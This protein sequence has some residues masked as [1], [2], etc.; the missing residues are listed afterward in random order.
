MLPSREPCER[1]SFETHILCCPILSR[2]QRMTCTNGWWLL[3]SHTPPGTFN[4]KIFIVVFA[5]L[6]PFHQLRTMTSFMKTHPTEHKHIPC[7]HRWATMSFKLGNLIA[8]CPCNREADTHSFVLRINRRAHH[9]SCCSVVAAVA[10]S[11]VILEMMG[12]FIIFKIASFKSHHDSGRKKVTYCPLL[13]LDKEI[14]VQQKGDR[15]K[16]LKG[17]EWKGQEMREH[18]GG[19]ANRHFTHMPLAVSVTLRELC[20]LISP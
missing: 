16:E 10:N 18:N 5:L 11:I 20:N 4:L 3:P 12:Y 1:A 13:C 19:R 2:T 15:N 8:E 7:L 14:E 9:H 6:L 17:G